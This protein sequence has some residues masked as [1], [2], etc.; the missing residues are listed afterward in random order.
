MSSKRRASIKREGRNLFAPD[1]NPCYTYGGKT[2]VSHY[3]RKCFL[4]GWDQALNE[5][6]SAQ[7]RVANEHNIDYELEKGNEQ[8]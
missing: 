6:E 2:L 1:C 5:Y 4:E 3:D 7:R 8:S